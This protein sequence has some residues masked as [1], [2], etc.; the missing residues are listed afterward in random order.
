MQG[1]LLRPGSRAETGPTGTETESLPPGSLSNTRKILVASR[2]APSPWR[3]VELQR[4]VTQ[5]GGERR[6]AGLRF[7]HTVLCT[8]NVL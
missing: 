8:V 2:T 4:S 7:Q 5:M 6:G 1:T 3:Q